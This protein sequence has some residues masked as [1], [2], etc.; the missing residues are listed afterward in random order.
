M[1]YMRQVVCEMENC[2][3]EPIIFF[4]QNR[5][6]ERSDWKEFRCEPGKRVHLP[7]PHFGAR[8]ERLAANLAHKEIKIRTHFG[9]N[10]SSPSPFITGVRLFRGLPDWRRRLS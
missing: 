6:N 4:S 5:E 10:M 3:D 7:H 2:T 9:P 8:F 1:T